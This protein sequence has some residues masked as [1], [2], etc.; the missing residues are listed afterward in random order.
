VE[1]RAHLSRLGRLAADLRSLDRKITEYAA[2]EG[3]LALG[4]D[5]LLAA[6]LLADEIGRLEYLV[7]YFA[8][9]KH[10]E[11]QRNNEINA[12]RQQVQ[13]LVAKGGQATAWFNPELAA[14]PAVNRSPVDGAERRP[15]GLSVAIEEP[16]AS[17]SMCWT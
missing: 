12:K 6:L 5:K 8:T 7:W 17:R 14:N 15:R 16:I 1:S 3:T 13:I 2:L 9:L 10:D 4:P 11:D